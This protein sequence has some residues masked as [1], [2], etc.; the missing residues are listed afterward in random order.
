MSC[1]G[2]WVTVENPCALLLLLLMKA[3]G[4]CCLITGA[5]HSRECKTVLPSLL[6]TVMD[7]EIAAQSLS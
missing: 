5:T 6:P 7:M 1:G 2:H 3:L 4:S